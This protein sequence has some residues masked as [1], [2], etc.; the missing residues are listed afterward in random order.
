[1]GKTV[2]PCRWKTID[3]V[4]VAFARRDVYLVN[5]HEMDVIRGIV[6]EEKRHEHPRTLVTL[7]FITDN[8]EGASVR[9]STVVEVVKTLE[10]VDDE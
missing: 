4:D 2:I 3:G 9:Y 5:D 1:M 7:E 10:E 6:D 8:V